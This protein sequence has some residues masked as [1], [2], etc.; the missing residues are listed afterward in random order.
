MTSKI[1]A[2]PDIS[3]NPES[4]AVQ[5]SGEFVSRG[6]KW[7][8][9]HVNYAVKASSTLPPSGDLTYGPE[10]LKEMWPSDKAWSEGADGPGIGEWLELT[11]E[12]PKRLSGIEILPGYVKNDKLFLANARPRKILITLNDESSF[13]TEI[14]DSPVSFFIP[15]SDY[16]KPVKTIRFTF[17]EVWPGT[18]YQDLCVSN[19]QLHVH[20][21][22]KPKIHPVR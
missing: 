8:I 20:L 4:P 21:D 12:V 1:E 13:S 18:T 19:I 22:R 6:E 11:P 14:P 17:Q 5:N 9:A 16:R 15:I 2:V 3:T 10:N 7:S